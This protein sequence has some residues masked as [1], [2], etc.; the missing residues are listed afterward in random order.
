M[1]PHM[2]ITL[3]MPRKLGRPSEGKTDPGTNFHMRATEDF[4]RSLDA[5]RLREGLQGPIPS[6]AEMIR[7][8]VDRA[9][10]KG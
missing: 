8:L 7:I 4:L 5:L 2:D 10:A 6:R 3:D 1:Y 9:L